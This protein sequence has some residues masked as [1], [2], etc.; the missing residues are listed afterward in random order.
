MGNEICSHLP[1]QK[2]LQAVFEFGSQFTNKIVTKL[3][4]LAILKNDQLCDLGEQGLEK[5]KQ[6]RRLIVNC[7]YY[8]F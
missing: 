8:T 1:K 3:E 2:N 6:G 5:E 4:K 7:G